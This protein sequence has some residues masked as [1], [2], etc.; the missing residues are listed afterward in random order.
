MR[1]L[2]LRLHLKLAARNVRRQPNR[3]IALG[4]AIAFS[5]LVMTLILGFVNGM[6]RAIQDNVTLYAGGHV[7]ISGSTA[8]WSGRLQNRFSDDAIAKIASSAVPSVRTVSPLA[9]AQATVVFGTREIQLL[10][11]GIDWNTDQLYHEELVLTQGDWKAVEGARAM[12]MSAQI[13]NRF[14]LSVGDQVVV[15]LSTASGQ[16]NVTDYTVAAIYDDAASGGMNTAFVALQ[17]LIA[18]LNMKANE[19]QQIA[20]FLR[21]ARRRK[22]PPDPS[23]L[24]LLQKAIRLPK[25]QQNKQRALAHRRLAK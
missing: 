6:D 20:I 5:A 8:S 11:R 4:G 1:Q 24:H 18:D 19:Q 21:M 14:G 10:V 9:Q 25:M 23:A 3:T 16:Q 13:A 17:D 7:I 12:L 22:L 2:H 15:R